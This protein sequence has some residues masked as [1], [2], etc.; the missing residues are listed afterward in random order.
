M[1]EPDTRYAPR[2]AL[3]GGRSATIAVDP[4][5]DPGAGH[6]A[7]PRTSDSAGGTIA[8]PRTEPVIL[9]PAEPVA[10]HPLVA[11]TADPRPGDTALLE[12]MLRIHSH[13]REERE[14]ARF[15]VEAMATRGFTAHLD[16]AGNAVGMRGDPATGPT[17]LLLGHMDTVPGEV[18]VRREVERLY[19][20][21]AVDAKGPLATFIAAATGFD[22]PGQ[23]IVVGAVEEEAATSRGAR[24]VLTQH[25]PDMAIIGEPS[26]WDRI[27]IGYKGR[28]LADYCLKRPMAHTAGAQQG[29]C[30]IAAAFWQAVLIEAEA[31]NAPRAPGVFERLQPSL[32]RMASDSD[33][34]IDRAKLHL[35]F[36]LPTGFDL[37][38]WQE[39]LIR[40]ASASGAT[41]R[42]HAHEEA[43]RVEKNTPLAR[44]MLAAIRTQGG[45][46]RFAVKTGTSDLNVVAT[47][48]RCPM[49]AYGPGDSALDHTP[50]EHILL[51]DYHRAILVLRDALHRLTT[52]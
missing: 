50:D 42:F 51:P 16:A 24:H 11:A 18:H 8:E 5:P 4:N 22:G 1:P 6:P 31:Y 20:R 35:G 28:L 26:N 32:R 21:G 38:A 43:V 52:P 7:G 14:L 48:W 40:L 45:D 15:L 44:A 46:A 34:L 12:S 36:R 19:G 47:H 39:T 17:I 29:V 37:A 23:V 49:L 2:A 25:D 27:T 33:G 41:I 30:E 13:S 10:S 9:D 3:E